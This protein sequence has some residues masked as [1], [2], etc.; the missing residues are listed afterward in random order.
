MEEHLRQLMAAGQIVAIESDQSALVAALEA[1]S[2]L[3]LPA[4]YRAFISSHEFEPCTLGKVDLFGNASPG[5]EEDLSVA[6]FK[7]KALCLPL[8]QAGYFPIGRPA[9][10]SYDPVCLRIRSGAG[11]AAVVRID[12][13]QMLCHGRLVVLEELAPS[14][15]ALVQNCIN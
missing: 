12:H 3:R 2:G 7:D 10:F 4:S 14:F 5:E 1:R 13:E 9:S 6:P 11:E 8:I 15:A